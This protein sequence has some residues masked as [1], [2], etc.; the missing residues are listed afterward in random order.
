[1]SPWVGRIILH[2]SEVGYQI[3]VLI[4]VDF[5]AFILFS[6]SVLLLA[7]PSLSAECFRYRCVTLHTSSLFAINSLK[8]LL[9]LHCMT[10]VHTVPGT[11]VEVMK[12]Y[13]RNRFYWQPRLGLNSASPESL[14]SITLKGCFFRMAGFRRG[15]S[16]PFPLVLY[17]KDSLLC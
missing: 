16:S 5:I 12:A 13:C 1:M 17:K 11:R 15:T 10:L 4:D 14:Y 8:C 3:Y 2:L 6:Y 9:G 7:N